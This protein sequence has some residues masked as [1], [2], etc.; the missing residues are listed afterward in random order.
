MRGTDLSPDPSANRQNTD[1]LNRGV[2]PIK[3][4]ESEFLGGRIERTYTLFS[5]QIVP[6]FRRTIVPCRQKSAVPGESSLGMVWGHCT[7]IRTVFAP[8]ADRLHGVEANVGQELTWTV[9]AIAPP[10]LPSPS[11]AVALCGGSIH[12]E[13][14]TCVESNPAT[15]PQPVSEAA[16]PLQSND[17]IRWVPFVTDG[18]GLK[19]NA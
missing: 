8:F 15:Q 12:S 5:L 19:L 16:H 11:L 9:H 17:K 7:P 3:C 6:G 10:P 2:H 1:C 18:I 13:S 14:M 4:Q